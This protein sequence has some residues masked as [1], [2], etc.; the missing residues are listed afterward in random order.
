MTPHDVHSHRPCFR[1]P[2]GTTS[3][4]TRTGSWSHAVPLAMSRI[5]VTLSTHQPRSWSKDEAPSNM[6]L[7]LVM[8]WTAQ[9]PMSRLKAKARGS[10]RAYDAWCVSHSADVLVKGPGA[11]EQPR[12]VRDPAGPPPRNVAASRVDR[13]VT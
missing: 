13:S 7:M 2:A 3:L 12:H 11:V 6:D 9:S 8:L 4:F 5:S 1:T 10:A